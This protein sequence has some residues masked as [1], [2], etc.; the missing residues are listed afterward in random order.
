MDVKWMD[1]D[2]DLVAAL[3]MHEELKTE[4]ADGT[5]R[6]LFDEACDGFDMATGN[7]WIYPNNLPL[8]S[9]QQ[10]IVQSALFKNTLVVL[11]TGLGKT[12]IAAVVMYNFYRWYPKGKIVF[13]APTRPL[14]SQQI[15]AS[16]K[17]MPFPSEDTVQ[18]TG[19]LPRPKRAELWASKRVFFATPQVVH[20]DMLEADG[21]SSFPFGSIKLIVVDEAH[22]AKG[23]YAYTQV[24][25]C[26][27]ARNRHFRMLAL[28]ATPGRTM[29]DVAAVCRNLYIS[30]LQVRWDTSIDVQPYIH[31][32]TIRTIVV[33]LKERIK[34]PRERLLQIIEPYL[35]QLTEAEIFK[36]NKGTVSRNSLLFEQKSFVE[37]SAQGQ[38]HPD[39][40]IIMSNFAMCISMYHSLELMERHGLRVFVNNFDADEDGREKFV[41]A[42]D[43]NLRNLV[44]QVRQEL[45][46][47][48]LDYT[49]HAMT[50]GEVPPLPSD[51]DFGHAKYE[52]LR[53]VLVQH[54]QANPD[55]RA[56]VFCEYRESVMLIH[57]LLLQ[58]RPVL[59]PRCFVGQGS[60]VGASYAL[61]QK[62]QL[63]IMTDFRSGT[64]N[65]LVATSIGEEGL[66]V[67]EVEMIVCFDICSTNPTRFIQR[68]GR[69]GRK[70][71]GEVVM[72][73]TEGR[74]QQVLKDVLAN[75]D[76]INKKLLNSSVVK[77]SLY[78]QNPR[79]V[80]SKFQPK[81]VEKHMEP[82]A[83]D[84][85]KPKSS[86]KTK[87]SRKRK[88][89]VAQTGSLRKYFKESPPTESQHG[90]LQGIKQYQMSDSSQQLVKQQVLRR[91]VTLKNFFGETQA[92]STLTSSQEDVQRLR[93]L[94]RLLQ[95]N[96]PLVS[97]SKDL[98]SHLQDDHLPRQIKLY[99]LK[100][101]PEFLR[102]THSKMQIQS[103][104]NIA[105]DRLNSRQRR[106]RNN[107]QLLLDICDGMDQMNELLQG[108]NSGAEISF[109]DE[110]NPMYNRSPKKFDTI[111]DKIFEGLN[112]HG[113]N[114]DNFELKQDLLEKLELRNLETTVNEQLGGIEDSWSE[115]EWDQQEE[116]VKFE[117]MYLSQQLNLPDADVVPHSSTPLRVKPLSKLKFETLQGDIEEEYHFGMEAS[118]LGDNL[119][120][121][122]SLMNASDLKIKATERSAPISIRDSTIETNHFRA[123]EESQRSIPIPIAESSGESNHCHV[124]ENSEIYPMSIDDTKVKSS[125]NLKI[126]AESIVDDLDID[127]D[128]FLEPMDKELELASQTI[129]KSQKNI[130]DHQTE[131]LEE[132]CQQKETAHND[133]LDLTA[134]DLKEFLEPMVEEVELMSQQKA[135][136]FKDFLE[137]M[138]EELE[139]VS[140]QNKNILPPSTGTIKNSENKNLHENGSRTVSPDIFGSDSM[141]PL[142]P[143]GKSLAAKLAAKAAA[144]VLP[145][146]PP[147]S[148]GLNSPENRK[149]TN[150]SIQ[151]KSPSIFDLYLNRMRGRGRLA[152]AAENLHRITSTN[153]TISVPKDE[154]DSPIARRPSKRKIVISSDE[155]EEQKPQVAET[156]VDC[157][158]DDYERILDTQM[159]DPPKT[160]TRPRQKRSKFNSFILDEAE[161]SGSDHEEEGETT[162]GTYLKDSM[163][164]SSDD[165]DHN[166]TNNHA[167]YLRALKSPIQRPGAFKMP[168]PRVFRDESH[169]FSQPVEDDSSQYMQ[170]SFIVDD[171]SSTIERGHDVSE[172]PLEKAERIL[173]ERRKQRRLGK[174]PPAP[175]NKR[176]RLQ[177]ISTSS[178]EDDVVL[179]D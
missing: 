47:N 71:N 22:R 75:K 119:G 91:S 150:S 11:P 104:L 152:K 18:L 23:R 12:F 145:C 49:T 102:E 123:V 58:H 9:Y 37:R 43:G 33:S 137:P 130:L 92:S 7:N 19:Q 115:E 79:M 55:S 126:Q 17:I 101:N 21:G 2:E 111:C 96:K 83:E 160:P 84:E 172:C 155:E 57:R 134:E 25:D 44:E 72:L 20:S 97:D 38:R 66:D 94:T 113:L 131:K 114:S 127:L 153:S 85:P 124:N 125:L 24:A 132:N 62:Q 105:D 170:C 31:R 116:D 74:E 28:S 158:S 171:E 156:Q 73:V 81:C 168:P 128:D 135:N 107:Y 76:Q 99:L 169:I 93:K 78:E 3:A 68:I 88:Q 165:E 179:I 61:T 42:R 90:I 161:K 143:Q 144:K 32:R 173:K 51:L 54:F 154:E 112:E 67:G 177:T 148:A 117:S 149:R 87:E 95:S 166:D 8:R 121:L 14:V 4:D 142:K 34:E 178:D 46:A 164:V 108:N 110:L 41:L 140:P 109:R 136:D 40:N 82:V 162:I 64:S 159:P 86:A 147:N 100:S 52:K 16:Q 80:P 175:V 141:S 163:I 98:M 138:A 45:G 174:V 118:E 53:Q 122:N 139:L 70:K 167:I 35:R 63:Q 48:P 60:T 1:D 56:I 151:D 69:T 30:N 6:E 176:R 50:N 13:M 15:H 26:L 106:T 65:V 133:D 103:E 29:E 129:G 5:R 89:P 36:G 39:H 120:R 157:E 59:R 27:M 77:F 146:A 10:T